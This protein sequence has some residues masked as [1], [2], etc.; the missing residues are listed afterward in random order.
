[1]SFR[2]ETYRVLI[3]SPSDLAE[4]RRAAANAI[5]E[6]N[7]QHAAA[8]GV[9]LLPVGWETHA[10]PES[11]RR[12][13]DAINQQLVRECDLLIGMFWTKLGTETGAAE[14]GT[15][16]E[17]DQF[18][19]GGKPAMLYFSRR[20]V[21]PNAIDLDQSRRLRAFKVET[22]DA[23]LTGAFASVDELERILLRDLTRQVRRLHGARRT[24]SGKLDQAYRLTELIR[25]HK[26]NQITPAEFERYRDQ[27]LG[28]GRRTK[29]T[30]T[31]P[32][33]PGE[34]G[35]NGYRVGYTKDGDKVEWV[36]ADD[37]SD[38][39]WP[40]LLRRGDKAIEKART[41]FWDKVWWNR[42]QNWLYRIKTGDEPLTDEQK[43]IL[44]QAKKAARRIER[45]YGKKNLGWDDFEWGLLS[46]KLSSL[47]WV[48][49][50]EWEESLDT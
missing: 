40:L 32:V 20:P 37:G 28:P 42:H 43:P 15:V 7:A 35:P 9:V 48:M 22:F 30:V 39:E 23:A 25:L 1:M 6:W 19:A 17:I 26:E 34:V 31:D 12:P 5:N 45:K 41:E 16:E 21:D 14:S 47:S 27:F 36:P 11:G 49:G 38:E 50:M 24:G 46:G 29:A 33:E 3:A 2:A 13:Q 44:E 8:E 10:M 4:E 18:V